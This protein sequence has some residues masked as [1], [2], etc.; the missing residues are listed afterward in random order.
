MKKAMTTQ[1]LVE[2]D[3]LGHI[4]PH[5]H[6]LMRFPEW[7][8]QP[9]YPELQDEKMSLKIL[10][11][12]RRDIWSCKDNLR[13]DEPE[14][15]EAEVASFKANGGGTIVDVTPVGL[16]RDV[17]A[18]AAIARKTGVKIVVG[19]GYYIHAGHPAEVAGLSAEQIAAWM[20]KEITVEIEETG[21]RAGI[22]GEIG[23][24]NLH[25]DEEKTLRAAALAQRE[26]GAP[27]SVHQFGGKELARIHA[28][29]LEYA[30]PPSSVVLCHMSS[31][32]AEERAW[33][34]GLGYTIEF[35]CFGN[36][37]Y[38]DPRAGTIV[39]DPDRI[40]MIKELLGRGHLR[41]ILVS[42]DIALKMLLKKYGGWGYEHIQVNARPLMLREGLP[43]KTIDT[44]LYYNPMRMIAYLD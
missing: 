20:V 3:A 27:I 18:V 25:P 38:S 43:P 40:R 19:T 26:T 11:R 36:E 17:T 16:Q 39:R 32:S 44:L 10:G 30:V 9:L 35:D 7:G 21:I 37:Y 12:L 28:I 31:A 13:L 29:L 15:M 14:V 41:Q 5:E 2:A 4:L 6:I 33:A 34:A 22:I 1:G 24:S 23:I 8:A 42:N